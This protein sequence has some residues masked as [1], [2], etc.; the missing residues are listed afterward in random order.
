[1]EVD[2]E[3]TNMSRHATAVFKCSKAFTESWD[4]AMF[5][6]APLMIVRPLTGRTMGRL[7]VEMPGMC[8]DVLTSVLMTLTIVM[9]ISS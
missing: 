4:I 7:A 1:M 6:E 3:Y 5:M 8:V 2:K 9:I